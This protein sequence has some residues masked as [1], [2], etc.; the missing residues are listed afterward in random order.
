MKEI[1]ENKER[2]DKSYGGKKMQKT[3]R[4]MYEEP[5]EHKVY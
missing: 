3:E 5:K 1:T 2:K 4:N